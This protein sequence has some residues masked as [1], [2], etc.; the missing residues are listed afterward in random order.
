MTTC[1]WRVHCICGMPELRLKAL[2][3]LPMQLPVPIFEHLHTAAPVE[4]RPAPQ[5]A[6]CRGRRSLVEVPP[7]PQDEKHHEDDDD[8]GRIFS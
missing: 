3:E 5:L 8:E 4:R 2:S 7:H 1:H 6:R